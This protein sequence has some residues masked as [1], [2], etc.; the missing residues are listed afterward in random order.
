MKRS[1]RTWLISTAVILVVG[2]G[3]IGFAAFSMI[4]QPMYEFGSV[5]SEVDLR[6]PLE[7]P[8]Q[9]SETDWQ[10]ESDIKLAFDANG[11]GRPVMVVHGGPGI[12][13]AD[14]WK[15]LETL[16][17]RYRFYYYLSE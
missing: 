11:D 12:P 10:M 9:G 2:A 5:R 14:S 3:L 6:G 1:V 4:G 8:T 16:T 13:Y 15:G 7:P 17:D